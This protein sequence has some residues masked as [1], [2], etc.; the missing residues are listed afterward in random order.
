MI[1]K[2]IDRTK[3]EKI[4]GMGYNIHIR[5]ASLKTKTPYAY[6]YWEN[7]TKKTAFYVEPVSLTSYDYKY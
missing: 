1:Q 4:T 5:K 6:I 2:L 3:T 7:G